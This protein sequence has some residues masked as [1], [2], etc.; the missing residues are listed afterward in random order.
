MFR[1]G[2]LLKCLMGIGILATCAA[3]LNADVMFT[4]SFDSGY[5]DG[6]L[7]GSSWTSQGSGIVCVKESS[8]NASSGSFLLN[9]ANNESFVS[10][11]TGVVSTDKDVMLSSYFYAGSTQASTLCLTPQ[12][13]I[14]AGWWRG[15]DSIGSLSLWWHP[16]YGIELYYVRDDGSLFLEDH[17]GAAVSGG[18]VDFRFT[19][20]KASGAQDVAIDWKNASDSVWTNLSTIAVG[21][22]FS[23]DY[24]GLRLASANCW[25]DDV[26][27][28][29]TSVPEPS[30]IAL[31][32][33]GM[34]GLI[35]Y[36]WRKRR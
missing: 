30:S 13:E 27:F 2:I 16:T 6:D 24:V 25:A 10:R 5:A 14:G 18:K 23:A 33:S 32:V 21:S 31:L 26:H 4:D 12:A 1:K 20:A 34:I 35:A 11:P 17:A 36:A 9:G 7:V 22:G 8:A 28:Q 29:S 19:A 15:S 3:R